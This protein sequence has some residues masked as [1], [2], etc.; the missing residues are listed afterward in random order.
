MCSL[1]M[2]LQLGFAS[3]WSQQL[4]HGVLQALKG[5][6]KQ[7]GQSRQCVFANQPCFVQAECRGAWL[8]QCGYEGPLPMMDV[9][10]TVQAVR[11]YV[12]SVSRCEITTITVFVALPTLAGPGR[13]RKCMIFGLLFSVVSCSAVD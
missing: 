5:Y 9:Y 12:L 13:R 10:L 2:L 4:A 3:S 6:C 11:E 8:A 1:I 7:A